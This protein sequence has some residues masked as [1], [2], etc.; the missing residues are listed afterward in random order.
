MGTFYFYQSIFLY[1]NEDLK[2]TLVLKSS[3]FINA[4]I[5]F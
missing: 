2:T 3:S 5:V 1:F 4:T